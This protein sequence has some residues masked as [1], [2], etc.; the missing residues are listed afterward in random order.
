MSTTTQDITT[1]SGEQ[2]KGGAVGDG[3]LFLLSPLLYPLA[4]FVPIFPILAGAWL[5]GAVMLWASRAWRGGRK[6]IGTFLTGVSLLA[7]MTVHVV[8]SEPVGAGAAVA[9]LVLV[10]LAIAAPGIAG[11]VY[12][13]KT[14]RARSAPPANT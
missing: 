12:L 5:L 6:L 9:I 13:A 2:R 11:V 3:A 7:L 4:L 8:S 14:K 1:R 10:I